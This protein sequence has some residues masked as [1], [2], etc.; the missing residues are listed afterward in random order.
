MQDIKT[1]RASGQTPAIILN[2]DLEFELLVRETRLENLRKD[3]EERD[4]F[5]QGEIALD[6]AAYNGND[7]DVIHTN[8]H[9]IQNNRA[10]NNKYISEQKEK[11][12]YGLKA[13]ARVLTE[14]G[15][16]MAVLDTW[17]KNISAT[18]AG[19]AP[20]SSSNLKGTFD[21]KAQNDFQV[22]MDEN[23]IYGGENVSIRTAEV[24]NKRLER[25]LREQKALEEEMDPA[26]KAILQDK[27]DRLV[28]RTGAI[29]HPDIGWTV[30]SERLNRVNNELVKQHGACEEGVVPSFSQRRCGCHNGRKISRDIDDQFNEDPDETL[31]KVKV[32]VSQSV[33]SPFVHKIG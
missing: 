16:N 19:P 6:N 31:G 30:P 14:A 4:I 28:E 23:F 29:F 15:I 11:D 7:S 33:A 8:G 3:R 10:G 17:L 20:R 21:D 22:V 27:F 9:V 32:E 18:V 25:I 5:N 12:P 24:F 26:K 1:I 13:L 2:K